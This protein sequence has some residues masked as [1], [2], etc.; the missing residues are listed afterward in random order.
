MSARKINVAIV[1]LGFGAE[2]IPI[3]QKHPNANLVAI[4][5]RSKDRLDKVGDAFKTVG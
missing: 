2:F 4:C 3:Y 5:Q 1:G